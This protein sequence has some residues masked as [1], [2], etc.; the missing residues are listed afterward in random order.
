MIVAGDGWSELIKDK[1][2][3]VPPLARFF[4]PKLASPYATVYSYL[5]PYFRAQCGIS[6]EYLFGG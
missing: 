3:H 5:L 6:T 4:C 1:A 2:P